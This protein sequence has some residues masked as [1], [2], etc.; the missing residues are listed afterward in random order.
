MLTKTSRR[1][2]QAERTR[3]HVR[4]FC[5]RRANISAGIPRR[6]PEFPFN[7]SLLLRLGPG[8]TSSCS[9]AKRNAGNILPLESCRLDQILAIRC[10]RLRLFARMATDTFS[11][12]ATVTTR[13][14]SRIPRGNKAERKRRNSC[15]ESCQ[16]RNAVSTLMLYCIVSYVFY[17]VS[18][19]TQRSC[20]CTIDFKHW[21]DER[22]S[23]TKSSFQAYFLSFHLHC[24]SVN[25]YS[26][27]SSNFILC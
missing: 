16:L 9:F 10:P 4:I 2:D 12:W 17:R 13:L 6:I 15:R 3:R 7:P 24:C 27:F 22:S 18:W 21:N 23:Y 19:N 26:Y 8:R 11:E 20:R 14:V 5:L 25:L 1:E